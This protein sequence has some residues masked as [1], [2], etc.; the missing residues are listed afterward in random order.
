M[1]YTDRE[2]V[3]WT[4]SD[5]TENKSFPG[6]INAVRVKDGRRICINASTSNP[7]TLRIL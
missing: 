3:Q 2:G 1:L 5:I 6:F 7:D 4:L